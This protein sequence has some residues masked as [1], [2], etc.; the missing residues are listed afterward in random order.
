MSAYSPKN[1]KTPYV[2]SKTPDIVSESCTYGDD[3]DSVETSD[4]TRARLSI[5]VA[6]LDKRDLE[7]AMAC[8]MG[9]QQG[10][11]NSFG[12]SF[13]E[14]EKEGRERARLR[15]KRRLREHQLYGSDLLQERLVADQH[16]HSPTWRPSGLDIHSPEKWRRWCDELYETCDIER[17]LHLQWQNTK[18]PMYARIAVTKILL[19]NYPFNV[20]TKSEQNRL[21]I[22]AL[23]T[24]HK[25]TVLNTLQEFRALEK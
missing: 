7:P 2:A 22:K 8:I 12:N 24:I 18:V 4:E 10:A 6:S 16:K 3:A 17:H 15:Y 21:V 25:Q 9:I 23:E 19:D 5:L 11:T 14:E 13:G 1:E 20:A